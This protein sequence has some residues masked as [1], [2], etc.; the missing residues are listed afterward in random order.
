GPAKTGL[1]KP[2]RSVAVDFDNRPAVKLLIGAVS[3]VE[4]RKATPPAPPNPFTPPPPAPPAVREEFRYAKLPDNPQVFEVKTEK[5]P[6]LF[7]A[8]VTLRDPKLFRF[9]PADVRRIEIV[10]GNEKTVLVKEAER[11]KLSEPVSV[12][13]DAPKVTEL[14]DRIAEL[15]ASAPDLLDP[16]DLKP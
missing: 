5:F 11:W 9:K 14:V 4:E 10:R 8:A 7:F 3:R 6:D 13:A 16:T 1:D 12:D 2:E 15:Q